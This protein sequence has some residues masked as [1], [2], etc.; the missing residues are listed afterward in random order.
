MTKSGIKIS[1]PLYLR[2]LLIY[3]KDISKWFK[4]V[5]KT[6]HIKI[7]VLFLMN[8]L[9]EEKRLYVEFVKIY[10]ADF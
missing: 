3:T 4:N 5:N 6:S 8:Q 10:V 2:S 7:D 1:F 9:D